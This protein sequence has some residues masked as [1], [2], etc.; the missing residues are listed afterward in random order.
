M[1]IYQGIG[2]LYFSPI[3][4]KNLKSD[5]EFT[6]YSLNIFFPNIFAVNYFIYS[7][8]EKQLK[9]SSSGFQMLEMTD[10]Y[11][12]KTDTGTI[13]P[14]RALV[15]YFPMGALVGSAMLHT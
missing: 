7:K 9:K 13:Q 3:W 6:F 12:L 15:S 11:T 5:Q 2:K 14:G 1:L 4:S 10:S 8:A